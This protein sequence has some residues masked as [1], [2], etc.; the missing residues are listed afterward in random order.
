[1]GQALGATQ[2]TAGATR[3]RAAVLL[4][5]RKRTVGHRQMQ[6]DA[7]LRRFFLH[8]IQLAGVRQNALAERKAQREIGQIQR[9]G[10]HHRVRDAVV[11]QR[12]RHLVGH[13][14][15]QA[16]VAAAA[17]AAHGQHA[18]AFAKGDGLG[19]RHQGMGGFASL[20]RGPCLI[21]FIG[22]APS[23]RCVRSAA[24]AAPRESGCSRAARP[25]AA[26]PASPVRPSPCTR[27]SW[28]PNRSCR[29]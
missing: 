9:S 22:F 10:Q 11:F 2:A 14:V 26:S 21:S 15:V 8:A 24:L 7:Q 17:H 16:E 20:H 27:G 18:R 13:P 23:S 29:W 28:W 1:M 19:R 4:Q 3:H 6:R 12:H 5:A 25:T